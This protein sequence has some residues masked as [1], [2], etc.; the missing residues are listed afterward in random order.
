MTEIKKK[1][2]LK[3]RLKGLIKSS[4]KATVIGAAI[5]SMTVGG[6]ADAAV[7]SPMRHGHYNPVEVVPPV[8]PS[9]PV[10]APTPSAP[11]RYPSSARPS[12]R[13]V[14]TGRCAPARGH[15]QGHRPV[16]YGHTPHHS[17][18]MFGVGS[19]GGMHVHRGHMHHTLR[20]HSFGGGCFQPPKLHRGSFRRGGM[21]RPQAPRGPRGDFGSRGGR[22]GGRR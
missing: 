15:H 5:A 19:R 10:V 21:S 16:V 17:R 18:P 7:G 8:V 13:P 12:G 3:S 22:R 20:G 9:A 6:K 11:V 2:G 1:S 4:Q 14:R